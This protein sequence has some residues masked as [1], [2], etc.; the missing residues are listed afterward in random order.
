MNKSLSEEEKRF[1]YE[2]I[3]DDALDILGIK[4][5]K[6]GLKRTSDLKES[7]FSEQTTDPAPASPCIGRIF[8]TP[9]NLKSII[10]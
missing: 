6:D 9:Q 4:H 10:F 8:V 7:A 5:D 1:F 3:D 2:P